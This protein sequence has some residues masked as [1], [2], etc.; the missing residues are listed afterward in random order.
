MY[1]RDA[2]RSASWCISERHRASAAGSIGVG[3]IAALSFSISAQRLNF[4]AHNLHRSARA[5]AD[6]AFA[7]VWTAVTTRRAGL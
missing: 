1:I 6:C 4:L 2:L 7:F 3:A 5:A